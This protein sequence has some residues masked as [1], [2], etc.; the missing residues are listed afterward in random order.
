MLD[1]IIDF[2]K[3]KKPSGV[4]GNFFLVF[5]PKNC[6]LTKALQRMFF[7]MNYFEAK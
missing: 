4:T 7:S 5:S 6:N 3:I 1:K 2:N